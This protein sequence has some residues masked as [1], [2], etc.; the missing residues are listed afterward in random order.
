MKL[1]Q[2]DKRAQ[3]AN[4]SVCLKLAVLFCFYKGRGSLSSSEDLQWR[5]CGSY[6]RSL[7]AYEKWKIGFSCCIQYSV[8]PIEPKYREHMERFVKCGRSTLNCCATV[9][10]SWSNT[11]TGWGLEFVGIH[12][13]PYS[14]RWQDSFQR[15]HRGGNNYINFIMA[16]YLA[17]EITAS[18]WYSSAEIHW[19]SK[20]WS[21]G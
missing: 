2:L 8:L 20:C 7:C 12:C 5:E 1:P 11:V 9:Q 18:G 10:L 14:R 6:M 15:S 17:G 13:M 16:S 21:N 3:R 19:T 4:H